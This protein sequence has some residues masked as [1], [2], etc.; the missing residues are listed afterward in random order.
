MMSAPADLRTA[1]TSAGKSMTTEAPGSPIAIPPMP[2]YNG[3]VLAYTSTAAIIVAG[4]LQNAFPQ[5]LLW[6]VAG[7]LTWPHIV[8]ILTRRTFLR[9]STRIRQKMLIV[10]CLI[11]GGFIGC[12]GL[13]V[14]PSLSVAL[15]LMFSCL[16]VG[17]IRQ[18]LLGTGVMAATIAVTVA[19]F[20]PADGPHA[21][22]L[23][24]IVSLLSTGLYICVTA[25][26]SHQQARALMLAKTQIQ[27]QREQSIAL[28][29]KLSKYLSP[30]V[31][32]SIFTGERD[33]RLETQRKK[34]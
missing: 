24:M 8:H 29:H 3:R 27:N 28:S 9:N 10:D 11:G 13:V 7:A 33:V 20:G 4:V 2:D 34:L 31:W 15:M 32:Q 6:L 19:I 26:Y 5:Q 21:P 23:T 1:S 17:G 12:I 18:W 22:L 14:M 30:Q 25:Y 16:I